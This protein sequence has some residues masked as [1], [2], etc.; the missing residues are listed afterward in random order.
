MKK[1]LFLAATA[2]FM[3]PQVFAQ[4]KNFEGLSLGAN[5]TASRSTSEPAGVA[6][7]SGYTNGV[8]LQVQ[9]SI[10]MAPRFLLGFGLTVGTTNNNA[11]TFAA[12]GTELS[13]RNRAAF[14][15]LPA[16]AISDT[17]MVFGKVAALTADGVATTA[18]IDT[19]KS[20]SGVGYG[21]GVRGLIDKSTFYQIEYDFNRY[22]DVEYVPGAALKG[23]SSVFS[24]GVGYKF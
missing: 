16:Y 10:A 12:T 4:A 24:L 5:V 1:I 20:L 17:M 3:A 11:G 7:E 9:Y 18:A 19:K 22:N 23:T 21:L 6:S 13:V 8:D 15:I 2:V 14:D